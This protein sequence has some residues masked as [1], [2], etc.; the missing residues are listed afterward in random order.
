[1]FDDVE[2]VG[3]RSRGKEQLRAAEA[4]KLWDVAVAQAEGKNLG[5]K[6]WAENNRQGALAVLTEFC[7][8]CRP[9]EVVKLKCRDVDAGG[10]LVW[11]RK[12][13]TRHSDRLLRV[14]KELWPLLD[15]QARRREQEDPRGPFAPV[16]DRKRGWVNDNTKRL[17]KLAG[18]PLVTAHSLRGMHATLAAEQGSTAEQI[19]ATLGHGSTQVTHAHY[20]RPGAMDNAEMERALKV[21]LRSAPTSDADGS[22]ELARLVKELGKVLDENP[23]LDLGN[24]LE[25]RSFQGPESEIGRPENSFEGGRKPSDTGDI[26]EVRRGGLEPPQREPLDP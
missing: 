11:F 20:I 4:H 19:A 26:E 25:L 1:V 3:Q 12:G 15:A 8:G 24:F 10:R 18:V 22:A 14:P 7:L 21:L 17:C 6:R 5:R 9:G 2:A 13:K 16:F 23:G